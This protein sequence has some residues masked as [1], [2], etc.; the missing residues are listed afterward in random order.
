MRTFA[1]LG[2]RTRGSPTGEVCLA[3]QLSN[4]SHVFRNDFPYSDE[5]SREVRLATRSLNFSYV[6]GND[7]I[8]MVEV[9]CARGVLT[10]RSF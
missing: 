9:C 8:Y 7:F 2:S 3:T 5:V 4:F 1:G 10:G 6:F